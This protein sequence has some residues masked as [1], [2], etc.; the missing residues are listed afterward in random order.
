MSYDISPSLRQGRNYCWWITLGFPPHPPCLPTWPE[1][2][3]ARTQ[4]CQNTLAEWNHSAATVPDPQP[5]D[6]ARC[7]Y[8]LVMCRQGWLLTSFSCLDSKY[9]HLHCT[10]PRTEMTGLIPSSLDRATISW[11][12]LMACS[13]RA[14]CSRNNLEGN[15]IHGHPSITHNLMRKRTI[16]KQYGN[17]VKD[18][19]HKKKKEK[20]ACNPENRGRRQRA[21]GKGNAWTE[22]CTWSLRE[23]IFFQAQE[24][25]CV[26]RSQLVLP[27]PSI[28]FGKWA[29]E[30]CF[31]Y[32]IKFC[33]FALTSPSRRNETINP[34]H[35]IGISRLSKLWL[36]KHPFPAQLNKALAD[37]GS[38]PAAKAITH[39]GCGVWTDFK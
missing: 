37:A 9:H 34:V 3:T 32:G 23:Q 29:S 31:P 8:K 12:R 25:P 13:N 30:L 22:C 5:S 11:T 19:Q 26:T 24:S 20:R 27:T 33:T 17:P 28:P 36:G 1:Q 39:V 21:P 4:H 2:A 38:H 18:M 15:S 10:K 14:S 7:W 6:D 16:P 35:K